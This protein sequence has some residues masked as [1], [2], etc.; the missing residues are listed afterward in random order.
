[1]ILCIVAAD[2]INADRYT[3]DYAIGKRRMDNKT[4]VLVIMAKGGGL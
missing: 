2:G 1:M 3:S 4:R